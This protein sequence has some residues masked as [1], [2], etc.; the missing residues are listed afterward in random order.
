M[1]ELILPHSCCLDSMRAMKPYS[2]IFYLIC[3]PLWPTHH[4]LNVFLCAW[5]NFRISFILWFPWRLYIRIPLQCTA[6]NA[7][8]I[9]SDSK[10]LERHACSFL[11]SFKW[12]F[13]YYF[14][15]KTCTQWICQRVKWWQRHTAVTLLALHTSELWTCY[16]TG[17]NFL[18]LIYVILYI[19]S[20][21]VRL[22]IGS[23]QLGKRAH[24]LLV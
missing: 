7:P 14:F 10:E 15:R 11:Q 5:Y 19:F 6:T 1:E 9:R 4:R 22:D 8:Y 12:K 16:L 13:T 3:L 21:L 17:A 18:F 24:N 23:K 2:E 20:K